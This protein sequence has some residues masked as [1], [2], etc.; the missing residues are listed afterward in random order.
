MSVTSCPSNHPYDE[1]NTYSS[2]D[3]RR[4]CRECRRTR[5]RAQHAKRRAEHRALLRD[6]KDRP[7]ADC[8]V[9]FPHYVMEFDHRDGEDKVDAVSRLMTTAWTSALLAE[10][11]KCD[12]VCANCHRIRTYL[13]AVARGVWSA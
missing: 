3:G 13:R 1:V 12:V 10:I 4:R 8:R 7:C 2:G 11:A 5:S 9:E 6:A